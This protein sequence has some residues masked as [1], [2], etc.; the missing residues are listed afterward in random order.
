MNPFVGFQQKDGHYR[1]F[2]PLVLFGWAIK[3]KDYIDLAISVGI[4]A[5]CRALFLAG[6][7]LSCDWISPLLSAYW[8]RWIP[9]TFREKILFGF[10]KRTRFT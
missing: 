9:T 3:R 5:A 8:N 4:E 2:I 7:E 1:N 6:M 10:P